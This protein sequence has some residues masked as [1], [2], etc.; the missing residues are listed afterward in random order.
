M[1]CACFGV[2]IGTPPSARKQINVQLTD[3]RDLNEGTPGRR[4]GPTKGK[5][6][7]LNNQD[8]VSTHPILSTRNSVSIFSR[9]RRNTGAVFTESKARIPGVAVGYMEAAGSVTPAG[10]DKRRFR[11]GANR[12]SATGLSSP[13]LLLANSVRPHGVHLGSHVRSALHIHELKLTQTH[14]V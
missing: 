6:R 4:S 11:K 1:A 8:N 5:C 14:Q 3:P 13:F 9:Y 10:D 7:C 12:Q 2:A